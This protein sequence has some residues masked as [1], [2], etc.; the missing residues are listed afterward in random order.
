MAGA[1]LLCRAMPGRLSGGSGRLLGPYP[2]HPIGSP[3]MSQ[4]TFLKR[5]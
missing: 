4:M 5:V 3:E 2:N 1:R